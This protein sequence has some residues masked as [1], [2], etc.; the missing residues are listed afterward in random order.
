M[1]LTTF[2]N[3]GIQY[4]AEFF[5]EE[6]I[7]LM[8]QSPQ[9]V[10]LTATAEDEAAA[11]AA[12]AE[13]AVAMAWAELADDPDVQKAIQEKKLSPAQLKTELESAVAAPLGPQADARLGAALRWTTRRAWRTAPMCICS[14]GNPF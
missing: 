2:R 9:E 10:P 12:N 13:A 14:M 7:A 1:A 8:L 11:G 3:E 6:T 4:A 5:T